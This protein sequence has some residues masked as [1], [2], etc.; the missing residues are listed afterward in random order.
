MPDEYK[1]F[2]G[3]LVLGLRIWRLHVHTLYRKEL[4]GTQNLAKSIAL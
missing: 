4:K 1:T 3:F 2:S